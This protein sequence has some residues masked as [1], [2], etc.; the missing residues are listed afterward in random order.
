MFNIYMFYELFGNE[1]LY[2]V[3]RFVYNVW[4]K[5]ELEGMLPI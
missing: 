1:H 5:T 3:Q 2:Y 4:R